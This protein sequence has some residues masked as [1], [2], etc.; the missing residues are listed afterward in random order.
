MKRTMYT[1]CLIVKQDGD[2]QISQTVWI[3]TKFA[4]AGNV[5]KIKDDSD[6]WEDGWNVLFTYSTMFDVLDAQQSFK[7][8]KKNT[9]DSLQKEK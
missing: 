4:K 9:G 3:P 6:E 7:K 2:R 1:Q 5:I 8:H